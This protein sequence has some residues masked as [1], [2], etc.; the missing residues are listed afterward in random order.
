VVTREMLEKLVADGL[1]R[2]ITD[3]AMPEWRVPELDAEEPHPP[4]GYV[5]SFIAFHERGLGVLASKFMRSLLHYYGVELHNFAP[6]SIAQVAIFAAVYEGYL[7]IP[8]HWA[9][10]L[11]FFQGEIYT[12]EEEKGTR[13]VVS[14]SGCILQVCQ[15]RALQF[16]PA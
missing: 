14:A 12:K 3:H 13:R 7:G 1:L 11:H 15:D 10:W 5:V 16:I 6:N 2:P 8:P 9:L 4:V